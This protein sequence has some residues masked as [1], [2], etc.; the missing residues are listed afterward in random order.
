MRVSETVHSHDI[1]T[2]RRDPNTGAY[3]PGC[4]GPERQRNSALHSS[5]RSALSPHRDMRFAADGTGGH[6][7]LIIG[8]PADTVPRACRSATKI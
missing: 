5:R 6:I 4:A 8:S 7:A 1:P 2:L 3:R